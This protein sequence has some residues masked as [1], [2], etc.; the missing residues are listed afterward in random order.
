MYDPVTD[1]TF[2]ISD[3]NAV[4]ASHW[5]LGEPFWITAELQGSSRLH[6]G[7]VYRIE[8]LTTE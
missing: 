5:W 8:T 1:E 7:E 2:R 6:W 4:T 3:P